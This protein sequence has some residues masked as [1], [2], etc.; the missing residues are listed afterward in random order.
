[1]VTKWVAQMPNPVAAPAV[2]IHMARVRRTVACA[3]R[4][5]CTATRLAPRQ[6]SVAARR[7]FQSCCPISELKT[8]NIGRRCHCWA[9]GGAYEKYLV[10]QLIMIERCVSPIAGCLRRFPAIRGRAHAVALFANNARLRASIDFD[11]D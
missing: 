7:R 3:R 9:S 10:L 11:A 2:A 1:M 4:T 6:T 5:R 8:R